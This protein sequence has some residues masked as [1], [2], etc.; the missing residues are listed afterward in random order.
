[1]KLRGSS[2]VD[3][4]KDSAVGILCG[5]WCRARREVFVEYRLLGRSGVKVSEISLGSWLTYGGSVAEEQARACIHK[6]YELGINFFDTANVYRRGWV[7]Y[8]TNYLPPGRNSALEKR[9][10]EKRREA[11]ASQGRRL[12]T[13]AITHAV[14]QEGGL[15]HG[16]EATE[17]VLCARRD[18]RCSQ[19]ARAR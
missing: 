9:R 16:P 15:S 5:P 11:Q 18:H 13:L 2:G 10:S 12:E 14:E 3:A 6:A 8:P 1:V 4:S 7:R 19:G 17:Y